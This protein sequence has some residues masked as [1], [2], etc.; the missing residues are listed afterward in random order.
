MRTTVAAACSLIGIS[1]DEET[2]RQSRNL[3]VVGN[4]P[5]KILSTSGQCQMQYNKE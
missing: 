2:W 1:I 5:V 4:G 3:G